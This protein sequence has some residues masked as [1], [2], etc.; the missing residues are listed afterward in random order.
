MIAITSLTIGI[1]IVLY[2]LYS[3]KTWTVLS[4]TWI[5]LQ[6]LHGKL[7]NLEELQEEFQEKLKIIEELELKILDLQQQIK[8][9]NDF[10]FIE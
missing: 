8:V 7:K 1:S 3:Y 10:V 2:N 9:N 5:T 6:T 4:E